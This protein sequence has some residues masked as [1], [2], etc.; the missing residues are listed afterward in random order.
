[1]FW[2]V[3]IIEG[4][5][6]DANEKLKLAEEIVKNMTERDMTSLKNIADD[7]LQAALDGLFYFT[8]ILLEQKIYQLCFLFFFSKKKS[9]KR[10]IVHNYT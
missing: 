4:S 9:K 1:M 6:A 8:L 5:P 3:Q 10:S 2:F 7:E